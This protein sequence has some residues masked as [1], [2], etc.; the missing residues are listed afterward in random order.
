[1]NQDRQEYIAESAELLTYSPEPPSPARTYS[2]L[3]PLYESPSFFN[4]FNWYPNLEN[5][6]EEERA[7]VT[8]HVFHLRPP[9]ND[10]WRDNNSRWGLDRRTVV[11][12]TFHWL[13]KRW[14]TANDPETIQARYDHFKGVKGTNPFLK[15]KNHLQRFIRG[16]KLLIIKGEYNGEHCT[17]VGQDNNFEFFKESP[18]LK[19]VLS[20]QTIVQV[21][22]ENTQL[23]D[24]HGYLP[25]ALPFDNRRPTSWNWGSTPFFWGHRYSRPGWG[26]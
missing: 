3:A 5:L 22:Q 20:N 16:T 10:G 17:V 12:H 6:P 25:F 4:K 1:M 15:G 24:I 13:V 8:S 14:D 26:N 19:V 23:L 21:R 2:D 7:V 11:K 9:I 18:I